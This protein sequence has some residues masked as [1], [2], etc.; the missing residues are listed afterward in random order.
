MDKIH[1][2]IDAHLQGNSP[3]KKELQFPQ[4]DEGEIHPKPIDLHT[5][6]LER[7]QDTLYPRI[8]KVNAYKQPSRY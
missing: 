1:Y 7:F 4:A 5:R 6:A 8:T 3:T 2:F